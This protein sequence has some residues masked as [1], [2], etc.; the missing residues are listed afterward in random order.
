MKFYPLLIILL[1]GACLKKQ[2]SSQTN[3]ESISLETSLPQSTISTNPI[4]LDKTNSNYILSYGLTPELYLLDYAGL[5]ISSY[6][7]PVIRTNVGT[8]EFSRGTIID[9]TYYYQ[10]YDG[11]SPYQAIYFEPLNNQY[12]YVNGMSSYSTVDLNI[13]NFNTHLEEA[14]YF[15]SE[16]FTNT[17]VIIYIADLSSNQRLYYKPDNQT[18]Q[19]KTLHKIIDNSVFYQYD[20]DPSGRFITTNISVFPAFNRYDT[21]V[22]TNKENRFFG[23]WWA[24]NGRLS[25]LDSYITD[26]GTIKLNKETLDYYILEFQENIILRS[27]DNEDELIPV[28]HIDEKTSIL[29]SEKNSIYYWF[30]LNPTNNMSNGEETT[31]Y[32]KF[33]D[34]LTKEEL[35]LVKYFETSDENFKY[36]LVI[37]QKT[38]KEYYAQIYQ[39]PDNGYD[40]VGGFVEKTTDHLP[41]FPTRTYKFSTSSTYEKAYYTNK[42][43]W[44]F[45][46]NTE[47]GLG[48]LFLIS[49]N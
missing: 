40:I 15:S 47:S 5:D 3:S 4:Y 22:Y 6:G 17:D 31:T 26:D 14:L 49:T 36:G 27:N 39:I 46:R 12:Y 30:V 48:S 1:F 2:D 45:S 23:R 7:Y 28:C 19:I 20:D 21:V 11:F 10:D 37:N 16:Q 18:Y 9:G 43:G 33:Q 35:R 42:Q 41:I 25:A 32:L 13:S 44:Q 24:G 29:W 34:I 38:Q 8:N